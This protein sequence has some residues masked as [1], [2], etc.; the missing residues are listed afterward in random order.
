MSELLFDDLPSAMR[1][2]AVI[3]GEADCY[4]YELRR[5]W[6]DAL[7]LLVVCMLNPS[8]ADAERDDPTILALIHFGKLWGYGGLLIVNLFA[9]RAASPDVMVRADDARG[10]DNHD[11]HREALAYAA[12]TSHKALVAWGSATAVNP[13]AMSHLTGIF[14]REAEIWGVELLC[15]GKTAGGE[16]KH[17]MARGKHRIARDQQPVVWQAAA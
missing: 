11:H 3:A 14:L 8:T 15:L 9:F 16:P 2:S 12:R 1:R 13:L 4:R 6:D 17:P 7:P 10:P 5:V